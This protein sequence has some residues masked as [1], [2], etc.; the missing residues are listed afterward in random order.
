VLHGAVMKKTALA[1]MLMLALLFSSVELVKMA[2]AN[3]MWIFATVDPVP[4]TIPPN[5]SIIKPQ[6]NTSYSSN[7]ITVSFSVRTA[8]LDDWASFIHIVE[9]SLDEGNLIP[10]NNSEVLELFDAALNLT[11]LPSGKH[12]LTVTAEVV[13][14]RGEPMEKFF[15]DTNSTVY[16]SIGS[17]D[18]STTPSPSP[19]PTPTPTDPNMGPTSPPDREPLLTQE[20]VLI[21]GVTISVLAVGLGL[22]VYGIKRK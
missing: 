8:E 11:L 13:V 20:Q 14:Y 5:I 17:E 21:I 3:F 4:G 15:L 19:E 10:V 18:Y 7:N 12:S 1:I 9:Y 6:N 2:E 22:L 16:F